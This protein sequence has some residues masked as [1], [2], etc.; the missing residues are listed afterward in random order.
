MHGLLPTGAC[1]V[2]GLATEGTLMGLRPC[3]CPQSGWGIRGINHNPQGG[4]DGTG[5]PDR[6]GSPGETLTLQG[7]QEGHLGGPGVPAET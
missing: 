6:M 3:P 7:G 2:P 4:Q 1:P 5:E